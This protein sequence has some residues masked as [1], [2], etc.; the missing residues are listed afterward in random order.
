[1][2]MSNSTRVTVENNALDIYVK[3]TSAQDVVDNEFITGDD[4]IESLNDIIRSQ[5][6]CI[7][8]E[9]RIAQA[10][11]R[12][13]LTIPY[14]SISCSADKDVLQ[15]LDDIGLEVS[16]YEHT[17][18]NGGSSSRPI[19][20]QRPIGPFFSPDRNIEFNQKAGSND[21][22]VKYAGSDISTLFTA[23][24]SSVIINLDYEA[25]EMRI[26][27]RVEIP[28]ELV[29]SEEERIATDIQFLDDNIA[30]VDVQVD[31][32]GSQSKSK[33][34]DLA[35]REL[36]GGGINIVITMDKDPDKSTALELTN[37]V[38][39][40]KAV[41]GVPATAVVGIN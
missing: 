28:A 41:I 3:T 36:V 18:I 29:E 26:P 34:N 30:N 10:V 6:A 12:L 35:G 16:N 40:M 22:I 14:S 20:A 7:S 31:D 5:S 33:A 21:T 1:M 8:G 25:G 15:D 27:T 38:L 9:Y 32:L 37:G 23:K 39:D 19:A 17:M 13:R 24:P 11:G 2:P 4:L